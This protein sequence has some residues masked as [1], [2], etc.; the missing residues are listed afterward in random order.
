MFNLTARMKSY[1]ARCAKYV[2][3]RPRK[4]GTGFKLTMLLTTSSFTVTAIRVAGADTAA[5]CAH[6]AVLAF[7]CHQQ[8]INQ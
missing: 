1:Q 4:R 8:G 2:E 5:R 3:F 6:R 7:S